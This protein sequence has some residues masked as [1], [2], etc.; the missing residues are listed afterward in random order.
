M[1]ATVVF[2]KQKLRVIERFEMKNWLWMEIFS[3]LAFSL[4]FFPFLPFCWWPQFDYVINSEA[5]F[6]REKKKSF[7][8]CWWTYF[9][10]PRMS[11][12][13]SRANKSLSFVSDAITLRIFLKFL[14][15]KDVPFSHLFLSPP[16]KCTLILTRIIIYV[17]K[18]EITIYT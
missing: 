17:L 6:D 7:Y 15:P 18:N 9:I 2:H 16:I 12:S 3:P 4:H 14:Y 5:S 8:F 11:L 1:C 10:P 13:L